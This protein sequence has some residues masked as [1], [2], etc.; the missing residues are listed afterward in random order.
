MQ[1]VESSAR[2]S[3]LMKLFNTC[4]GL[5]ILDLKYFV[6]TCS[7]KN[8]GEFTWEAWYGLRSILT[9]IGSALR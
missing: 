2:S 5:A 3:P 6:K 9:S 4:L 1:D 8:M 7:I